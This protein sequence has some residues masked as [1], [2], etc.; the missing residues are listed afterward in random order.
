ME[1]P[2]LGVIPELQL[3]ARPGVGH[4]TSW[5]YLDSFLLH[6]KGNWELLSYLDIHEKQSLEGRCSVKGLVSLVHVLSRAGS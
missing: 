1:A 5:F 2:R 4:A 3:L 6:H